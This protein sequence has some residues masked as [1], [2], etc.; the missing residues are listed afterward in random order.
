MGTCHSSVVAGY[1]ETYSIV[2]P[3]TVQRML[4]LGKHTFF[5]MMVTPT[6]ACEIFFRSEVV[7]RSLVATVLMSHRLMI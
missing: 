1:N 3:N 4:A 6:R 2:V 7:M 5:N